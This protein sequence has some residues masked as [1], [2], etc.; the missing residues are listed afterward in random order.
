MRNSQEEE[1]HMTTLEIRLP[2]NDCCATGSGRQRSPGI[3]MGEYASARM[4]G[5]LLLL[6]IATVGLPSAAIAAPSPQSG[7]PTRSAQGQ[8]E[9]ALDEAAI[10]AL[11]ARMTEAW[12]RED[13]RDFAALFVEDGELISGD[14]THKTGRR[15]IERYTADLLLRGAKANRPTLFSSEVV[16]VRFIDR[17]VALLTLDGGFV[18]K[19]ESTIAPDQQGIQSLLA[20]RVAGQWRAVLLQRTRL[21]PPSR[22]Q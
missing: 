7:A 8:S 9:G 21:A 19:G 11:A 12:N 14:G 10:R 6:T 22:P 2:M 20:K 1:T 4:L 15:E 3:R 16:G 17:D 13:S 5:V 18:R